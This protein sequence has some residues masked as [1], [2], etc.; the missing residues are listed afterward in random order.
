[1]KEKLKTFIEQDLLLME[2]EVDYNDNL[3][4][5]GLVDSLGFVK[6]IQFLEQ[7]F[8]VTIPPKDMLIENF[9][10]IAAIEKYMQGLLN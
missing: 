4:I 8:G 2:K 7:S 9:V 3:L 6:I 1:M 10:S 5:S